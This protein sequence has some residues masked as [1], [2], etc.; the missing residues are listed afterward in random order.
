MSD[1]FATDLDL[2]L[3]HVCQST[4]PLPALGPRLR[5]HSRTVHM[6]IGF[7]L[8]RGFP[9][10]DIDALERIILFVGVSSYIGNIRARQDPGGAAISHI[11]D[12]THVHKSAIG[13]PAFTAGRQAMHTDPGPVI[14][15][16]CLDVAAEGGQ[17]IIASSSTIYNRLAAT[18]P[19]LLRTLSEDWVLDG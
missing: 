10:A 4:F 3:S 8:L 12:L 13:N 16:L 11:T 15:M 19:D 6:G 9:I 2:P 5:S 18:R 17:S 7:V 14:G 1:C